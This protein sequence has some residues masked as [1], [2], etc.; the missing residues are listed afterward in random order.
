[1]SDPRPGDL[2][3]VRRTLIFGAAE[4]V[5]ESV[6]YLGIEDR[7]I[8]HVP[9]EPWRTT[10]RRFYWVLSEGGPVAVSNTFREVEVLSMFEHAQEVQP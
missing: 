9:N 1:M 6:L 10:T 7:E 2:I 5:F 3:T 4:M 8:H